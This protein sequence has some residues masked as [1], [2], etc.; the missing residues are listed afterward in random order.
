[1]R[2]QSYCDSC[3]GYREVSEQRDQW[4]VIRL[5]RDCR[6]DYAKAIYEDAGDALSDEGQA[7]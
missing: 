1:M 6:S 3:A 4:G 7:T 2:L 5:C